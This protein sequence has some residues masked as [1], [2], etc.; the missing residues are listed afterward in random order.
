LLGR[1]GSW[2]ASARPAAGDPLRVKAVSVDAAVDAAIEWCHESNA[3]IQSFV[4][5]QP[6]RSGG[7][8]VR[9]LRSGLAAALRD[10][11]DGALAAR[12]A[13]RAVELGLRAV[14]HV[15]VQG[16]PVLSGATKDCLDDPAVSRFVRRSVREAAVDHFGAR[17]E[18]VTELVE[19][20]RPR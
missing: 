16:S 19:R 1:P 13:R 20:A 7:S 18:L 15:R 17:D 12:S 6:T 2:E 10:L 14:I 8:H 9:G 3:E 4:N 11:A 5:L